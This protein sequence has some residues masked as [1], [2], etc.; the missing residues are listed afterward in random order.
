MINIYRSRR[1]NFIRCELY[2]AAPNEAPLSKLQHG[3]KPDGVFY[4]RRESG[5][6]STQNQALNSFQYRHDTVTLY[7]EDAIDPSPNDLVRFEGESWIVENVQIK[8]G[9]NEQFHK[10][11]DC[12][13]IYVRKGAK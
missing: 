3:A 5:H 4:S 6:Y 11:P 12:H 8:H 2:K 10:D 1:G 7:T 13:I 9:E